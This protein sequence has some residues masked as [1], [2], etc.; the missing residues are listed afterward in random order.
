MAS[1][2]THSLQIHSDGTLT[3]RKRGL[4]SWQKRYN[5]REIISIVRTLQN[6]YVQLDE[7]LKDT[8]ELSTNTPLYNCVLAALRVQQIFRVAISDKATTPLIGQLIKQENILHSIHL[9]EGLSP[10]IIGK[11][12]VSEPLQTVISATGP[13]KRRRRYEYSENSRSEIANA[14]NSFTSFF[15]IE[16]ERLFSLIGRIVECVGKKMGRNITYFNRFH[17]CRHNETERD[18][19]DKTAVPLSLENSN[20]QS[21]FVGHSTCLLSIPV[22]NSDLHQSKITVLTDPIDCG[23]AKLFYPRMTEPG[24][25]V[26]QLPPVHVVC[27]SHN[28]A[29][30]F[31][32]STL[33]KLVGMNPLAIVPKGDGWAFK[34]IG[35][36]RVVEMSWF[37]RANVTIETD[38]K[39]TATLEVFAV[40]ANHVAGNSSIRSNF[41]LF[42]GYVF[43]TNAVADIYFSG[44]TA[45]LNREHTDALAEKFRICHSFQQGGPDERRSEQVET[46]QCTVDALAMHMYLMI[47]RTYDD[48]LDQKQ[49]VSF[50]EFKK[51]CSEFVTTF[52]HMESFKLGDTH[53]DEPSTSASRLIGWLQQHDTWESMWARQGLRPYEA[54]V[55]RELGETAKEIHFADTHHLTPKLLAELLQIG[56]NVILPKIGAT[57]T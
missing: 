3:A 31:S 7:M 21:Y 48:L 57:S 39:K 23:I 30:H 56:K 28:H 37:E 34:K 10:C 55:L 13:F 45:R 44:D 36:T 9:P 49:I 19:Y 11:A 14:V 24:R 12:F 35:F 33:K 26:D 38:E 47:K 16:C 50:P 41:S 8:K 4:F 46:H 18:I 15:Q 53:F 52:M 6:S 27:L 5:D 51:R 42:N 25:T 40:P 17:Y 29:D 22:K 32:P 20:F 1:N 54:K 43:R 2:N